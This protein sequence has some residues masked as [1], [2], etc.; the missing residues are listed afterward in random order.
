MPPANVTASNITTRGVKTLH[1]S[2][3]PDPQ[4]PLNVSH[5]Y[6][7][8]FLETSDFSGGQFTLKTGTSG[9]T[10]GSLKNDLVLTGNSKNSSKTLFTTPFTPGAFTNFALKMDFDK[11]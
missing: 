7:L 2:L 8:T 10:D 11:K 4:R 5:E 6:L 9:G 3:M 1:F